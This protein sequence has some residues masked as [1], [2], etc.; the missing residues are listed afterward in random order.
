LTEDDGLN[1]GYE[2]APDYVFEADKTPTEVITAP[3]TTELPAPEQQDLPPVADVDLTEENIVPESVE[4]PPA[5][6]EEVDALI[7]SGLTEDAGT[8]YG[9]EQAPDLTPDIIEKLPEAVEPP[10]KDEISD[11][12]DSG[13]VED[14]GTDYGYEQAAPEEV[15][16]PVDTGLTEDD[17]LP[18]PPVTN[19]NLAEENIV[20]ESVERT[21]TT[22]DEVDAL[23]DSGLVEQPPSFVADYNLSTEKDP[24]GIQA[25]PPAY[26]FN[27]DGSVNYELAD[28][29]SGLG[30]QIPETPNLD[31]MGGGQGLT[32][33]AFGKPDGTVS[34]E[35]VF[36][37]Y[38]PLT[39][40][41]APKTPPVQISSGARPAPVQRPALIRRRPTQAN[42]L[43]DLMSMMQGAP[44]T[45]DDQEELIKLV[46][47]SP[48][49]DIRSPLDIGFFDVPTNQDP[50]KMAEGG[51]M[52]ILFPKTQLT[53]DEI[54]QI[55]EG[56]YHG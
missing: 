43:D 26:V 9:Y 21:P 2:Q 33:P 1:Y 3:V 36:Y 44:V 41:V 17:A 55:L 8:D 39:G 35:G 54:L 14:A 34:E 7:D 4:R 15:V 46:K 18:P 27:P 47:A 45:S 28:T 5:T 51:Y 11:L 20:P 50:V 42:T 49:F 38:N 32:A 16:A 19:V 13:L 37:D 52:D 22:Q 40:N 48:Y 25:S 23:I 29:Q 53:M 30:L 12:V 56:K 24:L 31:S 10:A 6:Q